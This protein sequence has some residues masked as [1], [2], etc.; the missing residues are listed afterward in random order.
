MKHV[1]LFLLAAVAVGLAEEGNTH[2]DKEISVEATWHKN[3]LEAG[4]SYRFHR[5]LQAVGKFVRVEG[6]NLG[7][8][9]VGP[10]AQGKWREAKWKLSGWFGAGLGKNFAGTAGGLSAE[11]EVGKVELTSQLTTLGLEYKGSP[12]EK[13]QH[14]TLLSYG[15]PLAEA[16][17]RLGPLCA[18]IQAGWLQKRGQTSLGGGPELKLKMGQHLQ[19]TAGY[20]RG[21]GHGELLLVVRFAH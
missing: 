7:L 1:A 5:N 18:G 17:Y 14:F 6:L 21:G 11:V 13:T 8:F 2:G 10:A 12:M 9:G 4:G 16:C 3:F 19:V 20:I 15:E